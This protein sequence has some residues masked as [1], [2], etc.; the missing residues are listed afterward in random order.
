MGTQVDT[1]F[2]GISRGEGVVVFWDVFVFVFTGARKRK[3]EFMRWAADSLV[4]FEV[5]GE[6]QGLIQKFCS[7]CARRG[8][9]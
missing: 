8:A 3:I 7:A 1:K 2:S 5:K 9:H 4:Y 6:G